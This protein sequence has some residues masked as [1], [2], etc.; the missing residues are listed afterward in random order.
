MSKQ[1]ASL[2][3]LRLQATRMVQQEWSDEGMPHSLAG[4]GSVPHIGL[5]G[6]HARV[7]VHVLQPHVGVGREAGAVSQAGVKPAGREHASVTLLQVHQGAATRGEISRI[8][9]AQS[10]KSNCCRR[11][12]YARLRCI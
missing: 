10:A 2:M 11:S 5:Q 12:W 8:E 1:N 6:V 7:A 4:V 3:E 9:G